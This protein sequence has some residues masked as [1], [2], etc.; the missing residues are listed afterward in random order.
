MFAT[1]A[2]GVFIS[3]DA[4]RAEVA[5]ILN[6]LQYVPDCIVYKLDEHESAFVLN[7]KLPH[8]LNLEGANPIERSVVFEDI[9]CLL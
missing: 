6:L 8:G 2:V 4:N 1:N 7:A 3:P 5:R 9:I